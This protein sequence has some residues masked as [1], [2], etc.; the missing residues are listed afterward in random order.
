MGDFVERN[1]AT[2]NQDLAAG[3]EISLTVADSYRWRLEII[4]RDILAREILDVL[5]EAEEETLSLISQA[6]ACILR[7]VERLEKQNRSDLI[8]QFQAETLGTGEPGRPSFNIPYNII[9][10]LLESNLSVPKIA[11]VVGVSVSTIRRRMSDYGLSVH[12]TYASMS[13]EELDEMVSEVNGSFP[14][15]GVRQMYGHLISLGIRLQYHRVRESLRHIDPNGSFLRRLHC[16]SRRR[17]SVPGP[18]SLWHID[19]HHK[20]IRLV[21]R[22]RMVEK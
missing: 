7:C 1:L 10:Y 6:Y 22:G 16:V 3:V 5:N 19:G 14:T 15:W 4:Y 8:H 11:A 13:D 9:Q 2:L 17:Y 18:R 20:L 12:D 21:K